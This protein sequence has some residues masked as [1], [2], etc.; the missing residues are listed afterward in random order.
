MAK[1]RI[2]PK[3]QLFPSKF[4]ESKMAIVTTRQ[5]ENI[6]EIGDPVSQAKIYEA[7][8]AD[9][10]LVV[11]LSS[12]KFE[13]KIE[14]KLDIISSIS[15]EVFLPLTVGGG[16]RTLYDIEKL[17]SHG[18]DKIS[19]NSQAL[20]SPEFI[21]EAANKFGSQCVV[22][23][24]D[25]KMN[26]NEELFVYGKGGKKEY[27]ISPIDWA[28]KV[29]EL[30]AGEIH[31]TAIENDGKRLGLDLSVA[32][33]ISEFI[34]IPLIL[35]GGCGKASHFIDGFKIGGAD[36]IAAGTFFCYRDQN[37]MQARGH[38]LNA[39]IKIRSAT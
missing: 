28:I 37:P 20:E 12:S 9:E 3:L 15:A 26:N 5:F 22:V 31:L 30:G 4:I 2:I 7:Q 11:D 35:S 17:L 14:V 16:I 24:I 27:E 36:A 33:N 1:K 6:V 29:Q 34:T 21:S 19:I 38:I 32:K 39:G 10:L 23:N 13:C 18:A 8:L 25:Y